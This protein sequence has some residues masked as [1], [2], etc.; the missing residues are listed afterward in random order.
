MN[1]VVPAIEFAW[2]SGK[3]TEDSARSFSGDGHYCA[4]RAVHVVGGT[5]RSTLDEGRGTA[6]S[7]VKIM[8]ARIWVVHRNDGGPQLINFAC[9]QTLASGSSPTAADEGAHK[10]GA[11]YRI[12]LIVFGQHFPNGDAWP[13]MTDWT[14]FSVT[15]TTMA[16]IA[17]AFATGTLTVEPRR[18]LQPVESASASSRA[19]CEGTRAWLDAQHASRTSIDLKMLI[20][21]S[22]VDVVCRSRYAVRI[23]D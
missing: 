7:R 10:S 8:S 2:L 22:S 19:T 9:A 11:L 12:A 4:E 14:I 1:G 6:S 16:A 23:L 17:L 20:E 18:E 5:A 15:G 13:Q 21:L 3:R